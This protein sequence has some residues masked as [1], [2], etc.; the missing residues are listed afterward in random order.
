MHW[1]SQFFEHSWSAEATLTSGAQ[2]DVSAEGT[3]V[4]EEPVWVTTILIKHYGRIS[5]GQ[6]RASRLKACCL[7]GRMRTGDG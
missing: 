6:G 3:P 4:D 1:G 5:A 7:E 2:P